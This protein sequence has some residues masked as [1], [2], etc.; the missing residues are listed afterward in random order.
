MNVYLHES[1]SV[2]KGRETYG[3]NICTIQATSFLFSDYRPCKAS[4]KGGGYDMAGTSLADCLCQIPEIQD[5]LN[6]AF[7]VGDTLPDGNYG[8]GRAKDGRIYIDGAIGQNSVIS[9]MESINVSVRPNY[10]LT[11]SGRNERIGWFVSID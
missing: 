8:I 4:C 3:Y 2:S 5:K 11:K 1:W 10:R 7:I 9:I 6:D